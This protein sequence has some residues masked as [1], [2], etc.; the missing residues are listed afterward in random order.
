MNFEKNTIKNLET[1]QK[2]S[3]AEKKENLDL[4]KEIL[5]ERFGKEKLP[6]DLVLEMLNIRKEIKREIE[7]ENFI[8]ELDEATDNHI[9]LLMVEIHDPKIKKDDIK[10][11]IEDKDGNIEISFEN[12]EKKT[13]DIEEQE[14]LF[15]LRLYFDSYRLA[16]NA[17][18]FRSN[19]DE[20]KSGIIKENQDRKIN[21]YSEEDKKEELLNELKEK[22]EKAGFSEKELYELIKICDL[23][24]INDIP[25]HKIKVMSKIQDIFTRFMK[26][27]KTKYVGISA[28]LMVPAFIQGY[29]PMLFA[30]AFKNNTTDINQI[31][32][33][34][35]ASVGGAG[36]SVAIQKQYKDFINSNYQKEGG[37]G[38]FT[39]K[40]LTEMPPNETNKFGQETVKNRTRQGLGS[41]E[42]V[43]NTFSFDVLPAVT[44]LTT[45]AVMLYEKSPILAGG[46]VLASGIT[47]ALDKY[48]QKYGKFWEKQRGA[49]RTQEQMSKKIS[50]Q[51]GAHMEIILAGEKEKF[52]DEIKGFIEKN[53]MAQSEK[54]F[55]RTLENGFYRFNSAINMTLLGVASLLAGGSVD[56]TI[57]AI[58][59]SNNFNQGIQDLLSTKR[60]LL[61][62]LR[63]VMQME[64]MFNGYA[65]EEE[66]KE[67]NRINISQIKN[68]DIVLKNV[69]VEMD[70]KK[71]LDSIDLNI[72][73]GSMAYLSGASG[74]GKTTLM[75]V[76]SGYY[77]PTSGEVKLGGVSVENIKKTGDE[78]IYNKIAY[79]SQFPYLFEG[80][81]KENL[82][83]G[84]KNELKDSQIEEILKE[85]GLNE[86]F[87]N[88]DEKLLGGSGNSVNTSGGETSRIGLARVLLKIRN[89]DSKI[90]FLDEPTASVDKKTKKDIAEIINNEKIKRPETTFIVISHDESFVKM[91]NCDIEV[92]MEKGKIL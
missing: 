18:K 12:G 73:S 31:I 55:F 58:M 15:S 74:A 61:K 87:S 78:S 22:Y 49:E 83:F 86:R 70:N 29:S 7:K 60:N 24:D 2:D 72:P 14:L 17:N 27:D 26:G 39:A 11:I 37:V 3:F 32:L 19:I 76:I 84:L 41:Y 69:N 52:F 44:T 62:S 91:L 47:I 6:K 67:K 33:F 9:K 4:F 45:S 40:N 36:L 77:H 51:L 43:L 28:A 5:Q 25:I 68:N 20:I 10:E 79:L 57:A 48:L 23:K 13:L 75:K 66:E 8:E 56:K 30:D 88:L 65:Q 85:V 81:L 34:A 59:Y 42:G 82:K 64:L 21:F 90:V 54:N 35:L 89:S 80:S 92:K 38:E 53:K 46:T 1:T 16:H 71:I 63:D 50:Q